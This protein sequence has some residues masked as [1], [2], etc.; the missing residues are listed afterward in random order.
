[1]DGEKLLLK[2][3]VFTEMALT[4]KIRRKTKFLLMILNMLL[5]LLKAIGT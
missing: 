1:M 3:C 5:K 2:K 4:E